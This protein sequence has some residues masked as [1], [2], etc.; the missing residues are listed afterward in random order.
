MS[1]IKTETYIGDVENV[2]DAEFEDFVFGLFNEIDDDGIEWSEFHETFFL[3]GG[4]AG[5]RDFIISVFKALG[6]EW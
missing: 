6:K 2:I 3:H 5:P 4:W 1:E